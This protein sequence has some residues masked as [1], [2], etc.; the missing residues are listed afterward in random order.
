MKINLTNPDTKENIMKDNIFLECQPAGISNPR[1]TW[2]KSW[3][4]IDNN[5]TYL[6]R[7]IGQTKDGAIY[8]YGS[9]TR[10]GREVKRLMEG[11]YV[12]LEIELPKSLEECQ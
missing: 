7:F 11:C 8:F 3:K 4:L 1:W 10:L 5:K 9:E 6:V 2:I 12:A